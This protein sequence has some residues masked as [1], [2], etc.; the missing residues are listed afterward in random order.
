MDYIW[1][2]W[3]DPRKA[4][5]VHFDLA[6]LALS[7]A[8]VAR[9][10]TARAVY[11]NSEG[12]RQIERYGIPVPILCTLD[13]LTGENPSKFA[14]AKID[15]YSRVEF[16]CT[17]ID[18]DVFSSCFQSVSTADFCCQSLES[19]GIFRGTYKA[20]HDCYLEEG[21]VLPPE[22]RPYSRAQDFRGYNMGF[23]QINNLE[24]LH[25]YAAV[26]RPIF[27]QMKT[28]DYGNNILP[29][30]FLFYCMA[31]TAGMRVDELFP[32]SLWDEPTRDKRHA[33]SGYTHFMGKK[34]RMKTHLFHL[35]L[36]KLAR[37]C[38]DIHA[39]LLPDILWAAYELPRDFHPVR[40]CDI[41]QRVL[42]ERLPHPKFMDFIP[43][44]FRHMHTP[45]PINHTTECEV[46]W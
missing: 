8:F 31:T 30:Q 15:T 16:P 1:T 33:E 38:P 7:S 44:Y 19:D 24:F 3:P 46:C 28:L 17:H 2:Y 14:L 45:P 36:K 20:V 25:K 39:A 21:G 12:A 23:V 42:H 11:T 41:C 4:A 35:V 37:L 6:C 22:M 32:E 5:Q 26:S 43:P 13:P 9:Y 10:T 34:T 27:S 18:Y 29:E 40:P